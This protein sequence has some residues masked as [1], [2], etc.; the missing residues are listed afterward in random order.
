MLRLGM[1]IVSLTGK[2]EGSGR[3]DRDNE[4]SLGGN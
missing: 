1:T 2:E 4:A 3:D